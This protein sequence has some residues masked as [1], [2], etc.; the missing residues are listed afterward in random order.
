MKLTLNRLYNGEDC[1]IG[2]LSN[3]KKVLCHTLENPWRDNEPMV[4]CIPE[5][6]YSCVP[7]SSEKYKDVWHVINVKDRS[8]IL[9]HAGNFEKDTKGC[10]LVGRNVLWNKQNMVTFSQHTLNMLRNTIG[11]SRSFSLEVRRITDGIKK[12]IR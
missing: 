7:Y 9:F 8:Y 6:T 2:T 5:G 4:S 10:I 12:D 3:D 1:T 11:I